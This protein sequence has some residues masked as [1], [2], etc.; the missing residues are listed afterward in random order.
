[1]NIEEIEKNLIQQCERAL[2]EGWCII[3][4]ESFAPSRK[5]CCALGANL[6]DRKDITPRSMV[7]KILY[8]IVVN[9]YGM[10]Q[11]NINDFIDGYD[12]GYGHMDDPFFQMGKRLKEK[13]IR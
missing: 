4:F 13:F 6:I 1:M 11:Q 12:N 9:K 5:L 8:D 7:T 2:A 3:Q 10:S